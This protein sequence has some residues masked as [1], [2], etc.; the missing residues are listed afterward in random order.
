MVLPLR[1][2]VEELTVVNMLGL[3]LQVGRLGG[4]RNDAILL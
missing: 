1:N 2:I 4:Q 3:I